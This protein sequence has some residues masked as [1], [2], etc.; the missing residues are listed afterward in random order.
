M[1]CSNLRV[2]LSDIR[3][4]GFELHDGGYHSRILPRILMLCLLEMM[5]SNME[6]CRHRDFLGSSYELELVTVDHRPLC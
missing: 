3:T 4:R 6:E 2:I 1:L 5:V